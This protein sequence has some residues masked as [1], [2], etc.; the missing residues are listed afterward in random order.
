[1]YSTD[2]SSLT[3]YDSS[4]SYST[5]N[6]SLTSEYSSS[7]IESTT[8]VP[9]P[10]VLY[11]EPVPTCLVFEWGLLK[12]YP[13]D[14]GKYIY[15]NEFGQAEISRCPGQLHFNPAGGDCMNSTIANCLDCV[16]TTALD[17]TSM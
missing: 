16:H 12:P 1:M 2:S 11:C 7:T 17:L 4:S 15:C 3:S 9:E 8:D 14:C 5:D 13:P 10:T 6:S